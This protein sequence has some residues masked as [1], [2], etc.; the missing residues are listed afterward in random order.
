MIQNACHMGAQ[1]A[2]I[3]V[4]AHVPLMASKINL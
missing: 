2:A 3:L 1:H 4:I